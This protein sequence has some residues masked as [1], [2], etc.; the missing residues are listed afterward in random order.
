MDQEKLKIVLWDIWTRPTLDRRKTLDHLRSINRNMIIHFAN[1]SQ[2]CQLLKILKTIFVQTF[3]EKKLWKVVQ[4]IPGWTDIEN[5]F[6]VSRASYIYI[7]IYIYIYMS[8]SCHYILTIYPSISAFTGWAIIEELS[9]RWRLRTCLISWGQETRVKHCYVD[10]SSWYELRFAII[11]IDMEVI[12]Y[13]NP[14]FLGTVSIAWVNTDN[15]FYWN[16]TWNNSSTDASLLMWNV[17]IKC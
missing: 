11:C 8:R 2:T 4:S 14:T 17:K 5:P 16:T 12:F 9:I 7:Y 10:L 13:C 15:L 1:Q 6:R 3:H